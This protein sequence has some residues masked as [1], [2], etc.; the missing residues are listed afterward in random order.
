MND[1]GQPGDRGQ[2]RIVVRRF[3]RPFRAMLA[4][5]TDIDG[6]TMDVFRRTH[7]FMNTLEETEMGPGVG[8]DVANSFWA[9][10]RPVTREPAL[11]SG[12]DW[13]QR[14][15][16]ADELLHYLRCGWIDT[17]HSYGPFD[18]GFTREH[19][20]R[21]LE[22][23]RD[24][25]VHIRV[26]VNHGGPTNTQ[27][28]NGPA[29]AKRAEEKLAVWEGDLEG[30]PGYHA[31][32]LLEHGFRFAWRYGRDAL[33]FGL[34][35]VLAPWRLADGA[36]MWGFSRNSAEPS[37]PA[38]EA[39]A[40]EAGLEVRENRSGRRFLQLWQP[41]YLPRQLDADKLDGLVGSQQVVVIAQHLGSLAGKHVFSPPT[42]EAF[43]LLKDYEDDGQIL[44]TSTARML[45][46]ERVRDHLVL[47]T[48]R[49]RGRIIIDIVRVAD[50]LFGE[51][52]PSLDDVR[53]I[54]LL[55]RDP[56][57]V[58]LR[59]AGKAL[60]RPEVVRSPTNDTEGTIGVRWYER[61]VTDY[62]SSWSGAAKPT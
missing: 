59:L 47:E 58:S 15:Q 11:F 35:H 13:T 23:L 48:R 54:T 55:V 28:L 3:P 7:R 8:L 30:S 44:V 29:Q 1:R 26:W 41:S 24:A 25:G 36:E 60:P 38:A 12:K 31:D 40:A 61:D 42:V 17:L 16:M 6:T 39:F 34:D 21:A 18:A 46:Y 62:A 52:V 49:D 53:G 37:S 14:S 56:R 57:R 2:E 43:R 22:A 45:Q 10:G 33:V 5:S 9:Y 27:N 19:A 50:P 4:I 51:F 20:A 32:L